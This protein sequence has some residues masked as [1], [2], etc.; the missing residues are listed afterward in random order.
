MTIDQIS[1]FCIILI[2]FILFIWGKWRYD[3]VSLIALCT[4]F[5][6][7]LVLGGDD[8]M[9]IADTSNLFSGFGHPAV[10]TVAAVLIISQALKNS[11]VVDY[12]SRMKASIFILDF[13]P[14]P[15]QWPL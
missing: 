10:I 14:C 6:V 8:S 11:G 4:L 9:L 3:I 15:R 13:R 1:I 5:I 12:I 2:T 7:D